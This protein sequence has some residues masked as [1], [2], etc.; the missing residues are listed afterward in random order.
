MT[1]RPATKWNEVERLIDETEALCRVYEPLDGGE[2]WSETLN[3]LAS[4]S[5]LVKAIRK[6]MEAPTQ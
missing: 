3:R 2:Q 1:T 5:R 4:I 6:K